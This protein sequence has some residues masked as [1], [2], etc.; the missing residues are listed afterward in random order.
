MSTERTPI[1]TYRDVPI[2]ALETYSTPY[3][4]FDGGTVYGANGRAKRYGG[5][6]GSQHA[7]PY[8]RTPDR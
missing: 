1:T 6:H 5:P 2:Y 8:H 4:Y 3:Y 7:D